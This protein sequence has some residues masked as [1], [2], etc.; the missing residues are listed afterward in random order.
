MLLDLIALPV[1]DDITIT[2]HSLCIFLQLLHPS[3]GPKQSAGDFFLKDPYFLLHHVSHR[4]RTEKK[5]TQ[6][7]NTTASTNLTKNHVLEAET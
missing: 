5:I 4:Q 2:K 3:P 6:Q 7:H 1:L